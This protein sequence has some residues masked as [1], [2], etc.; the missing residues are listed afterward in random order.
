[1]ISLARVSFAANEIG[2]MIRS[3]LLHYIEQRGKKMFRKRVNVILSWKPL[4]GPMICNKHYGC[5]HTYRTTKFLFMISS[6]C[7]QQ[8]CVNT[9]NIFE[10]RSISANSHS[11]S[12]SLLL[13]NWH[14]RQRNATPSYS[15]IIHKSLTIL[16]VS[17]FT[18]IQNATE[19]ENLS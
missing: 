10:Q 8:L 12:H 6:C 2:T 11:L 13:G 16:T 9:H 5:N 3:I 7:Y 19:L 14:F 1:M 18:L 15:M 4:E 17:M